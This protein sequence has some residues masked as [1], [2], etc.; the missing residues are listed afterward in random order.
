MKKNPA[1]S[2]C[3]ICMNRLHHLQQTFLK[4][5]HD[6]AGDPDLEFILLDY[7]SQ[8]GLDLWAKEHLMELI[9][10]GRVTYYKTFEPLAF[11]HSH[12]KNLAFRLAQGDIVCNVNADH[13]TGK[14]FGEYIKKSFLNDNNIVLTPIDNHKTKKSPSVSKDVFGRVCLKKSDF[15]Q[16]NGFDERMSNYGYEDF[17]FINRLEMLQVKRTIIA[18]SSF[19]QFIHHA[20]E[21]RYA[22]QKAGDNIHTIYIQH[23]TPALSKIILL[24]KDNWFE[25]GTLLNNTWAH[26]DNYL[27]AFTPG[28][29]RQQPGDNENRW[30]K[31]HWK[32]DTC[33][34]SIAFTDQSG[35]SFQMKKLTSNGIGILQE[36]T[37]ASCFHRISDEVTGDYVAGISH[38]FPNRVI[39][40]ENLT[41]KKAV[42]NPDGFGKALVFK[43]FNFDQP[44]RLT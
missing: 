2:F 28:K 30:V 17:D 18:N 14:G 42:V 43:N 35:L 38:T 21:E 13:Y 39:M 32:E 41:K 27:Y 12:A 19:L 8:D 44:L 33:N 23:C 25:K 22:M 36:E 9:A 1:I 29:L 26:A 10:T 7:N 20:E 4:N 24:Y 3:V 37:Q 40:E 11:S 6:N 31:G 34:Q 15:L 5:I 16:V